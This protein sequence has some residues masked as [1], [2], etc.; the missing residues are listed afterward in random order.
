MRLQ[1]MK[2][3]LFFLGYNM[4]TSILGTLMKKKKNMMEYHFQK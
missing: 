1:Q 2:H 4:I 3:L